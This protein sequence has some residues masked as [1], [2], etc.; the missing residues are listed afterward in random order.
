MRN[1]ASE[2]GGDGFQVSLDELESEFSPVVGSGRGTKF[3]LMIVPLEEI[4]TVPGRDKTYTRQQRQSDYKSVLT[5]T[6][7][8]VLCWKLVPS[9]QLI[10]PSWVSVPRFLKGA[11]SSV[12]HGV[13]V[14]NAKDDPGKVPD[15][16]LCLVTQLCPT[17]W[18]QGLQPT[19]RL[20][21]RDSP[22]KNIGSGCHAVLQAIFST[23]GLNPDPLYCRWILYCLNH[24]GTPKV[25]DSACQIVDS[26]R[27]ELLN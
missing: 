22:G 26:E 11:F 16:V 4:T 18:P 9:L 8:S 14:E 17:L 25:F 12:P 1:Q 27:M 6:S 20:C 19:R 7:W 23:Q 24:Q 21:P 13:I 5:S 3:K 2:Q 10:F 15:T